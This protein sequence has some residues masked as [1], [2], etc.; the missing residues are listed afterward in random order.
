L[1]QEGNIGLLR[2]VE[3]FDYRRGYKFSTY[4]IWWIRQSVLRALDNYS[5]VIRL[6]T[7]VIAK[8]SHMDRA[9]DR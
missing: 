2:A 5:R 8:V 1:V 9:D 6:P 3:K 4:A 7:Y